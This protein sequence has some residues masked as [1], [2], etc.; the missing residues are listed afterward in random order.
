MASTF[1]AL[2]SDATSTLSE[3]IYR[4]MTTP[5]D[6]TGYE[7]SLGNTAMTAFITRYTDQQ[8]MEVLNT[9]SLQGFVGFYDGTCVKKT[10]HELENELGP[11]WSP[12]CAGSW[13]TKASPGSFMQDRTVKGKQFDAMKAKEAFQQRTAAFKAAQSIGNGHTL[14]KLESFLKHLVQEL[15]GQVYDE[16]RFSEFV[17]SHINKAMEEPSELPLDDLA[18]ALYE[19]SEEEN[20]FLH[21]PPLPTRQVT[22]HEDEDEATDTF[23]ASATGIGNTA[24][25]NEVGYEAVAALKN[26]PEMVAFINRTAAFLGL[27]VISDLNLRAFAPWYDGQ[28]GV[29]TFLALES[30]VQNEVIR[31][32]A[33]GGGWVKRASAGLSLADMSKK[34]RKGKKATKN[35]KKQDQ[36]KPN[37]IE[38]ASA[39]EA[40]PAN[41]DSCS[42][43]CYSSKHELV[44]WTDDNY[45]GSVRGGRCG[46]THCSSCPEC[47]DQ[48]V[49]PKDRELTQG[50]KTTALLKAATEVESQNEHRSLN[51]EAFA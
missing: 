11:G 29:Q 1:Q 46:W 18:E 48:K 19:A 42:D 14:N 37:L 31:A 17:S 32:K 9:D 27:N 30:E 41:A 43:S 44:A 40:Q 16:Q 28:C 10:F 39:Q 36:K 25:L 50:R 26:S 8:N 51:R 47:Q 7:Q 34:R 5:L 35:G 24:P 45:A 20:S 38:L 15:K 3:N 12:Y 49:Q 13:I 23:Y 6:Q 22:L 33:C 2:L 21:L 4:G